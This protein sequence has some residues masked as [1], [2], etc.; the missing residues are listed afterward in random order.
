L[1]DAFDA[2]AFVDYPAGAGDVA[3]QFAYNHFDGGVTFVTFPRQKVALFEIGCFV[4]HLKL[5]PVLQLT[6][7]EIVDTAVGDENALFDWCELLVGR[8]QR[9]HQGS[10]RTD[11]SCRTSAQNEFT[12]QFQVFY[13]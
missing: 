11:Q 12:V 1:R 5:T 9:Q 2:D 8:A 4:R 13:F 10:V 7:R 6:K 3:A